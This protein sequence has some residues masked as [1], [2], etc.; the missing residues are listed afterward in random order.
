SRD[1]LAPHKENSKRKEKEKGKR[2]VGRKRRTPPT[3]TELE[4]ESS[5]T[6]GRRTL[7]ALVSQGYPLP[8]SYIYWW[9]RDF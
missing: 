7:G 9:F 2:E 8:S 6:F 5:S 1:P 4:E 3:Q